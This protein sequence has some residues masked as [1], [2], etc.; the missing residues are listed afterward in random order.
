MNQQLATAP[1]STR[2]RQ[3]SAVPL[4]S[5]RGISATRDSSGDI[6][7]GMTGEPL[8]AEILLVAACCR[9]PPSQPRDAAIRDAAAKVADWDGFLRIVARHRVGGL[10]HNALSAAGVELP[11]QVT[12][13]L[14][15]RAEE[16]ARNNLFL[17]GELARLQRAFDAARIPVL[18]LKGAP[19]AQFA[20]GSFTVK[21]SRDIDFLLPPDRAEAAL[22]LLEGEGYATLPPAEHLSDVQFR[23]LVRYGRE[24]D[25]ARPGSNLPIELQWRAVENPLLLEDVDARSPTRSI[26]LSH[27]VTVRTLAQD[28]LFAY[29]C[30]HGAYHAWS[31][32]KWLADLNALIAATGADVAGLFAHARAIGAG[33]C[34]GQ[35]LLLCQLLFD[36]GL[37]PALAAELRANARIARLVRIALQAISAPQAGKDGIRAVSANV[38]R[39][40]LLGQGWAYYFAQ[41]RILSVGIIDVIALPLP[42]ALQFLYPLLRLPLWLWRRAIAGRNF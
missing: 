31:R 38:H 24:V 10:V 28:D 11:S 14:A 21:E 37:P 6:K 13:R 18:V 4:D 2:H 36:L 34:A 26:A 40:F 1:L 39:Q 9:W 12:E 33:L 30:V 27:D 17:V 25:L 32:L 15:S 29:L 41:C 42:K 35:A 22:K 19:L 8:S 5:R 16:I 3:K 20:Y 7:I 23:A